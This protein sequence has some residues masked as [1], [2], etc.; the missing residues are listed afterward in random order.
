MDKPTWLAASSNSS[1]HPDQSFGRVS[2]DTNVS[3]L[4]TSSITWDYTHDW[5]LTHH[6]Q[7]NTHTHTRHTSE[8]KFYIRVCSNGNLYPHFIELYCRPANTNYTYAQM[9][10]MQNIYVYRNI[11]V[12]IQL[13][14][15]IIYKY[16]NITFQKHTEINILSHTLT[17]PALLLRPVVLEPIIGISIPRI[18]FRRVEQNYNLLVS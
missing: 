1:I 16:V 13:A 14:T 17:G 2:R 5:V 11:K 9:I 15:S 4:G 6:T 7:T 12:T 18:I 10:W 8:W 3:G